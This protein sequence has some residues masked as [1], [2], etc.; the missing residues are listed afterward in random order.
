[1]GPSLEAVVDQFQGA[2]KAGF[3][4]VWVGQR[5]GRDALTTLAVAGCRTPGVELGTAVVPTY[6]RHPLVLAAQALT[7]QEVVGGRLSLGLGVSHRHII[8]EQYGYS[9]DRPAR[10]LRE[11]LSVLVP[12]LRG[13]SVSYG[14]ETLTAVGAVDVAVA[15]PSVLVGALGPAMLRVAGEL[16]D[17]TVTTWATAS[18]LA[19]HV[20]PVI[21][22]AAGARTPRVVASTVVCVTSREDDHRAWVTEN[23]AMVGQLPVYRAMLDRGHAAGPQD[24]VIIGDE[25]VVERQIRR[26]F[27][28]GATELVAVLLGSEEEQ[29]RTTA[30][31]AALSG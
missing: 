1:M 23:F 12:L 13:E 21:T 25:A 7:V 17:G 2:A 26:L 9:F 29:A 14:S 30:L 31:L 19:E 24:T 27:D 4:G 3:A 28:A 16:A 20:V 11:Y 18:A 22:K 6:P 15:P 8:E 10:H 5:T